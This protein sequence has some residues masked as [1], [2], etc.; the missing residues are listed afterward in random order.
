VA[1]TVEIF[2]RNVWDVRR[3][4]LHDRVLHVG[5]FEIDVAFAEI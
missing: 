2:I 1:I 5:E 4:I 3:K